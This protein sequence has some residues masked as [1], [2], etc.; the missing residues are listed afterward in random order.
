MG[1]T[2]STQMEIDLPL[3]YEKMVLQACFHEDFHR[4]RKA[5]GIV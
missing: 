5:E 4:S 3:V 1:I 2:M